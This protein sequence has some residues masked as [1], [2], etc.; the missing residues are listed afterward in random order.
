MDNIVSKGDGIYNSS[1]VHFFDELP[2]SNGEFE[3]ENVNVSPIEF[4]DNIKRV[5]SSFTT[6]LL[7]IV[8]ANIDANFKFVP[9]VI[10]ILD[11]TS[12]SDIEIGYDNNTIYDF[13]EGDPGFVEW[14]QFRNEL[15]GGQCMYSDE[16]AP[17]SSFQSPKVSKINWMSFTPFNP[18]FQSDIITNI[19]GFGNVGRE[20]QQDPLG[21]FVALAI[22]G[23]CKKSVDLDTYIR[24]LLISLSTSQDLLLYI[25]NSFCKKLR[26]NIILSCL[27]TF[28]SFRVLYPISVKSGFFVFFQSRRVNGTVH[29]NSFDESKY[30]NDYFDN[31]KIKYGF[32][33]LL[34]IRGLWLLPDISV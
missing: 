20:P 1:Y 25:P 23:V 14:I 16:G 5:K 6:S 15:L 29:L 19:I 9:G 8:A 17:Y 7:G 28:E 24:N 18:K 11:I 34:A 13:T 12:F 21:R 32:I 2:I 27:N 10:P 31:I 22:T 4:H 33:N 3:F 30:L 26:N